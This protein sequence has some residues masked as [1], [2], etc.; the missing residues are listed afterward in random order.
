LFIP[1]FALNIVVYSEIYISS[2]NLKI[3]NDFEEVVRNCTS[4]Q[5]GLSW[6]GYNVGVLA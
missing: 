2:L 4:R 6:L 3:E 5:N 1:L